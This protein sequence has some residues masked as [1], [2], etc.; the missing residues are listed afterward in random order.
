MAVKSVQPSIR[1]T[2]FNCPHCG[3][4]T[5][6]YWSKLFSTRL[7]KEYPIPNFPD[8]EW[9]ESI[10]NDREIKKPFKTDLLSLYENIHSG[11]VFL[12][13]KPASEYPYLVYNLNLTECYNCQKFAVWVHDRLLFPPVK[14]GDQPNPDIPENILRDFEEARSILDLS[15][16][17]AVA[18]LR[19]AIQKL[20]IHLGE[21]GEKINNDIASL[22]KKGLDE[23]IQQALDTVR[24]IGNNAVHPGQIDLKDDRETALVLFDLVNVV[25]DEMISRK[26]KVDRMFNKLPKSARDAIAKRDKK[27][28]KEE[29]P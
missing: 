29:S 18:L 26:K 2:A 13:E 10:K 8:Q 14:S 9:L 7:K 4:L 28:V 23:H 21:K 1:E 11:M 22:V 6:Q 27:L 24:V 12:E 5:T 17:G 3:T 19:L 15:P 16:R 20:C 25:A